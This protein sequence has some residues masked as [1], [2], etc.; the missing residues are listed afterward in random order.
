MVDGT[1]I[2]RR[3]GEIRRRLARA[4][5]RSTRQIVDRTA[6]FGPVLRLKRMKRGGTRSSG[7]GCREVALFTR[8]GQ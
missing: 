1:P 5:M 6:R 2:E 7:V 3:S 8:S 4:P